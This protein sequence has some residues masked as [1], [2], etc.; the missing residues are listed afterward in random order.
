[1]V[2]TD[3]SD[4]EIMFR[5]WA[6]SDGEIIREWTADEYVKCDPNLTL[7]LPALIGKRSINVE[8]HCIEM[9]NIYAIKNGK[10]ISCYMKSIIYPTN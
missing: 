10:R 5:A 6:T 2:E 4:Y 1:M 8:A 3:E 7:I 9:R